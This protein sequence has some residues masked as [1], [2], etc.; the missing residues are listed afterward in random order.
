MTFSSSSQIYGGGV[1]A[2]GNRVDNNSSGG[3]YLHHGNVSSAAKTKSISGGQGS[4][5]LKMNTATTASN[6]NM[7]HSAVKHIRASSNGKSQM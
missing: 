5:M 7:S 6:S 1:T 4:A 2:D 3:A